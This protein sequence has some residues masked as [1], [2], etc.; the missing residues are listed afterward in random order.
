MRL[1]FLFILISS[2]IEGLPAETPTASSEDMPEYEV[3]VTSG[4]IDRKNTIVSLYLP[5]EFSPG[6]YYMVDENGKRHALQVDERNQGWFILEE[7]PRYETR[8]LF[9]SPD[10]MSSFSQNSMIRQMDDRTIAF[11]AHDNEVLRF[12]IRPGELPD[13]VDSV[14]K[15]AGYIHPVRTPYGVI[16]TQ[17]YA[18]VHPH[19]HGIWAAWTDVEIGERKSDFWNV[20]KGLGTVEFDSLNDSWEGIIQSGLRSK[21][22]Y[23]DLSS[24]VQISV[25]AEEWTVRVYNISNDYHVFDVAIIQ[26]AITSQPMILPVYRYGGLGFRG[27]ED[28]EGEDKAFF[29]TSEGRGRTDGYGTRGRWCHIGGYTGGKLAGISIFDHPGNFRHP[30]PMHIHATRTFFNFAPVHLGE[31][32]IEAGSPYRMQYRFVIYDGEPDTVE[33][34]RMWMDYA[35]PPSATMTRTGKKEILQE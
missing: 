29:I 14:Y 34:D 32:R 33:L 23:V 16:V 2:L 6:T 12:W 35:Y 30:Q 31:M 7:L 1:L 27:H 4:G 25:L 19:H 22:R 10:N 5:A 11:Y 8:R 20:G 28:W 3:T 13:G 9:L 26:S 18:E 24:G 21:H 17:D 15:R